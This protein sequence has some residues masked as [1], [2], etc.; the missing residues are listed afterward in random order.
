VLRTEL[1]RD[2]AANR[3]AARCEIDHA[4]AWDSG[5]GADLADLAS[6]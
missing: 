1:R 2:R 4:L 5:G 3:P 6:H